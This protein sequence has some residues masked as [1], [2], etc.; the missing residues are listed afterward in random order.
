MVYQQQDIWKRQAGIRAASMI[1]DNM[2]IGLGT[3]S[4]AAFF[5]RALAQRIEQ[6][7]LYLIGA[8]PSSQ[9][10]A[11]LAA[12][13][14]IPLT[15]L[16]AHPALDLYIDGADEIDSQLRLIKGGG[17]ALL[18]E[19]VLASASRRFTVIADITKQ[20]KRLGQRAPVPV[21]VVPFAVTPVRR[22]L[23]SL[24]AS[25]TLRRL[26]DS[27]FITEN[28]NIIL[29]CTFP[30]GISDPEELDALMH[31]IIGVVETG[32]FLNMANQAL[33][34]GPDGVQTLP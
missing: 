17:G 24:G 28:H 33:I 8:V 23:E 19:K 10:T 11:D 30:N 22:H 7:D 5:I 34:G 18:R 32:L 21:E 29:D 3:G 4:T 15:T 12:S 14:G 25:V 1:E 9:A 2:I 26:G 13:L 31:R 16:D 20:V 6:E 27:T